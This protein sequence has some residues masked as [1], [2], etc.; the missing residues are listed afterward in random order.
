MYHCF[1][2]QDRETASSINLQK[3]NE[4]WFMYRKENIQIEEIL[5][6]DTIWIELD[7]IIL[8]ETGQAQDKY[9]NISITDKNLKK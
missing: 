9:H 4:I 1:Q 6:L 7:D 8:S 2:Y 3:K 5:A